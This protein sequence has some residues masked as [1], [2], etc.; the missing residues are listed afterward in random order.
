MIG[1]D[2]WHDLN[3]FRQLLVNCQV[4]RFIVAR[5]VLFGH[6]RHVGVH[7][8]GRRCFIFCHL[9]INL[10][11]TS[12]SSNDCLSGCLRQYSVFVKLLSCPL[13]LFFRS[14]IFSVLCRI[15]VVLAV[16]LSTVT[17]LPRCRLSNI[18]ISTGTDWTRLVL[19]YATSPRFARALRLP[20][21]QS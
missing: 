2:D 16:F 5:V 10:F 21:C 19:Q 15:W 20:W 3:K 14:S 13:S 9:P 6:V 7:I 4:N 17:H 1:S 8:G 12:V 11:G 18:A